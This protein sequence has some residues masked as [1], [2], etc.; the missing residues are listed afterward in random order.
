MGNLE[1]LAL[2]AF[3][4]FILQSFMAYLQINAYKHK[5]REMR[6]LGTLGLG[7]RKGRLVAGNITILAVDAQRRVVRCEKME[8]ISVFARF[9]PVKA[10]EGRHIDEIKEEVQEKA[11]LKK[12]NKHPDP[13]L[14][15]I[16]GVEA[17]LSRQH[18]A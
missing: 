2:V 8:G 17:T 11:K 5:V 7:T 14:Q 13:L 18:I 6:P 4:L 9:R 10:L 16:E 1:K 3:G 15:A 12:K